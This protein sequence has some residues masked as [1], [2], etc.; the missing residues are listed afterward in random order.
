MAQGTSGAAVHDLATLLR[1]GAVGTLTDD[2][3]LERFLSSRGEDAEDAFAAVVERHGPMVLAVCRRI[4]GDLDDAEDAFQAVFLVLA[5]KA[6][7]IGR[8]ELLANWLYGVAVRTARELKA[9]RARRV[10][11]EK[12]VNTMSRSDSG[13]D[14]SLDEFAHCARSR[15]EPVARLVPRPRRAL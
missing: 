12:Q 1:S 4:L 2:Q 9:S 8:R 11:R 6:R 7:S 10:A 3:L 13:L 14:E 5:R 15:A